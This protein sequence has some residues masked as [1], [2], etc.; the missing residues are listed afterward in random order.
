MQCLKDKGQKDWQM[1][2]KMVGESHCNL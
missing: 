2:D 1:V